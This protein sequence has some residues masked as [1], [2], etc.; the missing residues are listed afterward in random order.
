MIGRKILNQSGVM[1]PICK[2]MDNSWAPLQRVVSS[3][4]AT[5]GWLVIRPRTKEGVV[6]SWPV[7]PVSRG[8]GPARATEEADHKPTN[9]GRR[10]GGIR[11]A[12]AEGAAK[13]IDARPLTATW[14]PRP[15]A[16]DDHSNLNPFSTVHPH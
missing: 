5:K 11:H 10:R 4:K 13:A 14:A 15:A 12:R 3:D 7:L 2:Q 9:K 16:R 6:M 1:L 8:E